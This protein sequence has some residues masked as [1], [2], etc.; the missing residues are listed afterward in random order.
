MVA[1]V[2]TL[3]SLEHRAT[4]TRTG[5]WVAGHND[6]TP[7]WSPSFILAAMLSE[8]MSH[9]RLERPNAVVTPSSNSHTH[10]HSDLSPNWS[11]RGDQCASHNSA[12]LCIVHA[13]LQPQHRPTHALSNPPSL[14]VANRQFRGL[15]P[16]SVLSWLL[17]TLLHVAIRTLGRKSANLCSRA[18]RPNSEGNMNCMPTPQL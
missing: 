8:V 5:R 13:R 9:Q 10:C 6:A 1:H 3:Q 7:H 4:G 17:C 2:A 16:S 14:A 12:V 18:A 15:E 11:L